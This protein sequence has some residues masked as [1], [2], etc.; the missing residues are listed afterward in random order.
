MWCSNSGKPSV[1]SGFEDPSTDLEFDRSFMA[2]ESYVICFVL[3]KDGNYREKCPKAIKKGQ[4]VFKKQIKEGNN[5]M[6]LGDSQVYCKG[7]FL[8]IGRFKIANIFLF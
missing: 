8:N 1:S 4:Y 5:K 6:F 2:T 7:K 3:E